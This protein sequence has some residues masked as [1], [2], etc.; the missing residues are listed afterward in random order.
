MDA[1]AIDREMGLSPLTRG[2]RA[3]MDGQLPSDGPIP[4]HAGEPHSRSGC[5]ALTRAYPRS[6]GGTLTRWLRFGSPVGLSPL[7]RGNR[8]HLV[9]RCLGHGPIPAHAGEP[10]S[11]SGARK[12]CGAYPRSRGGTKLSNI[13]RMDKRGLSPLTRGNLAGVPQH[14]RRGG[15]IPAHAGEPHRTRSHPAP[16]RAYPRSRGGTADDVL[17]ARLA[18]GLSPLTRGNRLRALMPLR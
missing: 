5:S 8:A 17:L 9:Q 3:S 6:R 14:A 11:G 12:T 13:T 1:D 15:P 10:K 4:A 18:K 2:N 16:A 7:T